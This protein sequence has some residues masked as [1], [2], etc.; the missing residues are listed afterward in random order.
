MNNENNCSFLRYTYHFTD[1]ECILTRSV[2]HL[3][4]YLYEI[5]TGNNCFQMISNWKGSLLENAT[6]LLL[7]LLNSFSDNYN[8]INISFN[9]IKK[10]IMFIETK[11]GM[12]KVLTK[13]KDVLF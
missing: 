9:L 2:E 8:F 6:K 12:N 4:D 10:L 5:L 7:E 13:F 11:S 1:S 3:C